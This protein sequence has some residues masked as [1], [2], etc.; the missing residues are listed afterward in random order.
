MKPIF[1]S[2]EAARRLPLLLWFLLLSAAPACLLT[3]CSS[4]EKPLRYELLGGDPEI[5]YILFYG[6]DSCQFVAPGP[7]LIHQSYTLDS[8]GHY[9][10]HVID[11]VYGSMQRVSP[12]TLVG[13]PPF[14]EGVWVKR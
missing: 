13:L 11:N 4:G 2:V 6:E 7:F 12:D 10:I 5:D 14:F 8:E 3:S 9:T 1:K